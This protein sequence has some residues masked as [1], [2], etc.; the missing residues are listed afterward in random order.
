MQPTVNG[1]TARDMARKREDE[2]KA[3]EARG[4]VA[5]EQAQDDGLL[6]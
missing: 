3:R 4:Q 6:A 1:K 5:A 2:R